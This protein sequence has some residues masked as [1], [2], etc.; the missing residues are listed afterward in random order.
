MA[1]E[2][3]T[4]I[5]MDKTRNLRFGMNALIELENLMGKPLTELDDDLSMKDM[6]TIFYVGLKW[7]DKELTHEIVGDLMDEAIF[8]NEEGLQ[9]LAGTLGEAI[10]RSLG[11]SGSSFPEGK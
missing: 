10:Q 7:E 11:S 2:R 6:R 9:Y 8:N 3:I 1:N 4:P 5:K